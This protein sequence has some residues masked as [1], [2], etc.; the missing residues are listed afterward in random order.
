[1][2]DYLT[3]RV[4]TMVKIMII[5]GAVSLGMAYGIQKEIR[6]KQSLRTKYEKAK[7]SLERLANE[8]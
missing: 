5:S 2:D 7:S 4:G 8:V 1:M 3:I 6:D